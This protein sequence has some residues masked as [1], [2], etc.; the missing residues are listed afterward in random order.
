MGGSEV[1]TDGRTDEQLLFVMIFYIQILNPRALPSAL[2]PIIA[3]PALQPA[4][5]LAPQP[6]AR[7]L[8]VYR[9]SASAVV[10][11][12]TRPKALTLRYPKGRSACA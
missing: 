12:L 5:K 11:D 4:R 8:T 6:I 1:P 3:A 2:L 10:P 7:A 9:F